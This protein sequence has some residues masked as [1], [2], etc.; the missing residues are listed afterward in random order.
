LKKKAS[1]KTDNKCACG[2]G[3]PTPL[4]THTQHSKGL[5]KG[6]PTRFV[7]GHNGNL[8]F[9]TTHRLTNVDEQKRIADCVICGSTTVYITSNRGAVCKALAKVS[10]KRYVV[11]NKELIASKARKHRLWRF[12]R[13]TP[14]EYEVIKK[15]Q[16][17]NEIEPTAL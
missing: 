10:R 15:Y 5:V 9:S 12:F 3:K 6:Q 14:E 16:Q 17:A 4:A 1:S 7:Q 2:C 11:A 8:P 13:I